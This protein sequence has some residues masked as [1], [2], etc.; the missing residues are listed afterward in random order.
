MRIA[1]LQVLAI[2]LPGGVDVARQGE[3]L[4]TP[5]HIFEDYRRLLGEGFVGLRGGPVGAIVVRLVTDD[6]LEGW[7]PWASATDRRFTF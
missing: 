6:G 1:S 7:A 2:P 3:F 4:V 5:M